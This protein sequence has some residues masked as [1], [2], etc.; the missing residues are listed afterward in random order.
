MHVRRQCIDDIHFWYKIVL[1]IQIIIVKYISC[2]ELVKESELRPHHTSVETDIKTRRR[3][4]QTISA[5]FRPKVSE[6]R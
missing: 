3:Y 1:R 6:I 5:Y 2:A 4:T